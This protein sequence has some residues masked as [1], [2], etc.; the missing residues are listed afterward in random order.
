M[1]HKARK[2]IATVIRREEIPDRS[3]LSQVELADNA[4]FQKYFEQ[5]YAPLEGT[6]NTEH[7]AEVETV[8]DDASS[9]ASG[10]SGFS[11]TE[12]PEVVEM[13]DYT[14][15]TMNEEEGSS[16]SRD[17]FKSYMVRASML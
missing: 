5:H 16:Q 10:W 1:S 14:R 2:P 13:V 8:H 4:L 3:T 17:S 9:E 7:G 6:A 15:T 12:M 11:D